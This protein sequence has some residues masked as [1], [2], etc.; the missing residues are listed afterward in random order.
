M[1]VHAA[2]SGGRRPKLRV[3][4][5]LVVAAAVAVAG[6]VWVA[7][8]G[9]TAVAAP[10]AAG[11]VHDRDITDGFEIDHP[12]QWRTTAVPGG[13]LMAI[14]GQ[15]AVTVKRT[16]L[17]A[18][19]EASNVADLRSV[20]DAVLTG[21]AAHLGILKAESTSLGGLPGIYYLYTFDSGAERGAHTHYFAFHGRNMYSLVFQ[22]LPDSGFAALAPTFD[23]VVSSFHVI[24]S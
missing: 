18:P 13:M 7:N 16:E 20:T 4:L 23:A 21:S 19:I 5:T 8:R 1:S 22:A 2:P 3:G 10:V 9:S 15:D 17:A 14:S 12:A 11:F 24:G 6:T